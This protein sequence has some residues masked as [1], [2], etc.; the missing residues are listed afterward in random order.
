MRFV[1]RFRV[2]GITHFPALSGF[3]E[4]RFPES[5]DYV[6]GTKVVQRLALLN[7]KLRTLQISVLRLT[8]AQF[9]C[10]V[11]NCRRW[12]DNTGLPHALERQRCQF[13]AVISLKNTRDTCNY[14]LQMTYCCICLLFMPKNM[15]ELDRF[16]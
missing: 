12:T 15:F 10:T 8:G 11:I 1:T 2:K 6:L 4:S 14:A 7:A 13:S 9:A 3:D 16:S 5:R